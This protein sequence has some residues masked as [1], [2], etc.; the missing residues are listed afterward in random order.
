MNIMNYKDARHQGQTSDTERTIPKSFLPNP[1]L[2]RERSSREAFRRVYPYINLYQTSDTE[3]TRLISD[4]NTIKHQICIFI[5]YII[6][7]MRTSRTNFQDKK[8]FFVVVKSYILNNN[9]SFSQYQHRRM[10]IELIKCALAHRF[11]LSSFLGRQTS[12]GSAAV[13]FFNNNKSLYESISYKRHYTDINYSNLEDL[14]KIKDKHN[15]WNFAEAMENIRLVY[16][17]VDL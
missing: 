15:E 8:Y 7:H 14:T 3:S 17:H 9:I 6:S 2:P 13:I 12:L 5:D 10:F 16:L 11:K 1:P 4:N